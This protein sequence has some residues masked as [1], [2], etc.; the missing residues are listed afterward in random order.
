[1]R[2]PD[3]D[4][5]SI[6]TEQIPT[7][8]AIMAAWQSQLVARLMTAPAEQ[9]KPADDDDELLTAREAAAILRRSAKWNLQTGSKAP[10][11]AASG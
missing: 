6:A 1:M 10:I 9:T 4:P 5:A 8:L 3:F 11:R 7:T 2:L